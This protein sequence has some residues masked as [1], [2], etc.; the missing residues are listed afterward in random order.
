MI[1]RPPVGFFKVAELEISCLGSRSRN[2]ELEYVSSYD[3]FHFP[4]FWETCF[5]ARSRQ[6][7]DYLN[8]SCLRL[9]SHEE[10]NMDAA[11]FMPNGKTFVKCMSIFV[12][13]P[14]FLHISGLSKILP[15]LDIL[16]ISYCSSLGTHCGASISTNPRQSE[17]LRPVAGFA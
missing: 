14:D 6:I 4:Y 2:S 5:S 9:D 17:I 12:S 3:T 1:F 10:V 8:F 15:I 13:K 11:S 7:L 16:R